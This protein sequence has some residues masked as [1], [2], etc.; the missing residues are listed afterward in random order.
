MRVALFTDTYLPDVNGVAKTL[1]RWVQFLQS[2]NVECKVFAPLSSSAD[3]L[4]MSIV[5]RF[6][7]IPFLLYPEC[8][9]AIPNPIQLNK[10]LKAFAPN[11][12]H[13]ATPFNLGITGLHYAKKHHVP[14]VASYH[15]HFDQYL[16]Y[17]KLQWMEPMLWKYMLWF[18]QEC[19]KIYVPSQSTLLHLQD[20]GLKRLEIW[21]RGVE[22][23]LF[24]PIV[25]RPQVW[26]QY[27]INPDRFVILYVG[28]LAPEKSVDVL[29]QTFLALSDTIRANSHLVITGDGPLYQ[30]LLENYGG[31]SNITFTGFQQ[32][33]ELS[34]L[35]AAADV[36]L[37]PSASETFGNV[38]LEAMASGTAV[39]G[40]AAG[41]VKDLIHHNQNGLLCKPGNIV[42]FVNTVEL[43]YHNEGRRLEIAEA[44][45]TYSM[46]QSWEQIFSRL[47]DS[48]LHV[49]SESAGLA[50]EH[51]AAM[52]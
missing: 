43:L 14:I 40:A 35:Y 51:K 4:G 15:T 42:E 5:E 16:S 2:R 13:V 52:K 7:S 38:I 46:Q 41:G 47:Y 8:R 26:R 12:I 19:Q 29:L 25:N 24:R 6:Y 31:A 27:G 3:D 22:E 39:I 21:S 32:G 30:P 17:Y 28:R 49:L 10:S 36:F 48:Y 20:K 44:G 1:G 33:R 23:S 34:R 18:H 11:L 45:R 50:R 9:M 37:F